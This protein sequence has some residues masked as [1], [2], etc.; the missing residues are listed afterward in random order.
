M[1][2]SRN[3]INIT[4]HHHDLL[5]LESVFST[6]PSQYILTIP[7]VTSIKAG[8]KNLLVLGPDTYLSVIRL[9]KYSTMFDQTT[10][11]TCTFSD[12]TGFFVEQNGYAVSGRNGHVWLKAGK[13]LV[14]WIK[15]Q[16]TEANR[17]EIRQYKS[18]WNAWTD[19]NRTQIVDKKPWWK[20]FLFD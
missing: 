12:A 14:G 19:P 9:D 20:S 17:R 18:Y 10:S 4:Q 15:S 6:I 8:S 11:K 2:Q 3:V 16:D 1:S 13:G 7:D 5:M